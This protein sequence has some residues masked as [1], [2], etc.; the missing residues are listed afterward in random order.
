MKSKFKLFTSLAIA[1][2]AIFSVLL[3]FKGFQNS[4]HTTKAE[5]SYSITLNN[6]NRWTSG[7][8]KKIDTDSKKYQVAFA[9]SGCSSY[10]AGHVTI[11]NEGTLKN[12][13][14]I[15]SITSFYPNFSC[16]DNVDLK[17]RA[18]YDGSH[19]GDYAVVTSEKLFDLSYSKP[20]YLEFKAY[21]G[22]VNLNSLTINYACVINEDAESGAE[23]WE[24][25]AKTSDLEV[26]KQYIITDLESEYG[27]S[28]TQNANN[29]GAVPLANK[30]L[31]INTSVQVVTLLKGNYGENYSLYTGDGYLSA[32]SGNNNY[33]WTVE[34]L[35]NDASW[36][37]SIDSTDSHAFIQ[38]QTSGSRDIL[39][40]NPNTAGDYR[41]FSCYS[42]S[43]ANMEAVLLYKKTNSGGTSVPV[44]PT[45]ID[46]TDS[47]AT[48]YKTNY[49]FAGMIGTE[50]GMNVKLHYSNGS[51]QTLTSQDFT[52]K[53][54]NSSGVEID[55]TKPFPA[56][57]TYQVSITD[58]TFGFKYSYSILVG[59]N[60][61]TSI[62]LNISSISLATDETLQLSVTEILP[63]DA[64]D[65]SITW[66]SS[67]STKAT[68]DQNGFVRAI[69][70][71]NVSITAT[72]NGGNGVVAT[73]NI[74][75]KTEGAAETVQNTYNFAAM[76]LSNLT[77]EYNEVHYD[78]YESRV[79][80]DSACLDSTLPGI[81]VTDGGD[82]Q[83]VADDGY[84]IQSVTINCQKYGSK[85]QTI[86]LYYW[87]EDSGDEGEFVET[88]YSSSNFTLSVGSDFFENKWTDA[89]LFY[90]SSYNEVGIQSISATFYKPGTV[91][92]PV[93][94]MSLSPSTA[95]VLV[96][97]ETYVTPTIVP[98]DATN[99]AINWSTSD[100]S[101]ATVSNGL[102]SGVS[103]GKAT[104]TATTVDGGFVDT[105]EVTVNNRPVTSLTLNKYQ[106]TIYLEGKDLQ[107]TATI[108]ND[109]TI[110][111]LVWESSDTDVATVDNSGKVHAVAEGVSTITVTADGGLTA[112]C[113]VTVEPKQ[114][115]GEGETVT[116]MAT[117]LTSKNDMPFTKDGITISYSKAAGQSDPTWYYDSNNLY[118][119]FR[120]YA[121]NTFTVTGENITFISFIGGN[122]CSSIDSH[123]KA[124]DQFVACSTGSL[125][126]WNWSCTGNGVDEVMF[127]AASTGQ[128]HFTGLEITI[129]DGGG[130]TPTPKPTLSSISVSGPRT[131]FT[132]GDNFIFGG[133]CTAIYSDSSE[134]VV[135]PTSISG[136]NMN[137][138]GQQT[139]TV[140]YKEGDVTETA[141]YTINVEAKVLTLSDITVT[142]GATT[143]TLGDPFS[144]P[145]VIAKFSDGSQVNVTSEATITGYNSS[146]AGKQTI[147]VSYTYNGTTKTKTYTIEVIDPEEATTGKATIVPT[148]LLTSYP[149][150]EATFTKSNMTFGYKSV[151]N[152]SSAGYIQFKKLVGYIRNT[153]AINGL[154]SIEVVLTSGKNFEGTLSSGTSENELTHTQTVN[155]SGT[156]YIESG[157][158]YFKLEDSSGY[159]GYLDSIT[160]NFSTKKVNPTSVYFD[161][162]SLDLTLGETAKLVAK[163]TPEDCNENMGLTWTSSN[164]SVA[165][166]TNGTINALAKGTTTI[167]ATST[168]N[169]SFKATCLITVKDIAVQ[170]I[171][172]DTTSASLNIGSTKQLYATINPS[173]ATN[174]NVTWTST[175]SNV[176][177]VSSTGLVTAKAVGTTTIKVSTQDG[178]KTASCSVEVTEQQ[179]DKWTIM[180]YICGADLES[181][182]GY[183]TSDIKEILGTKTAKPNDVNIIIQTGGTTSWSLGNTYI[184]GT[185]KIDPQKTQ[186]WHVEGSKL[187]LDSSLSKAN[188]GDYKTL[189][190]FYKWGTTSYPAQKTGVILWNHGGGIDGVCWDE[191]FGD[192]CLSMS[193][194]KT[195]LSNAFGSNPSSKLEWIGY[196]ACLMQC[197]EIADYNSK[198]FNYM[199]ASEESESGYGWDYD[200]WLPYVYSGDTT[201]NILKQICYTFI[202]EQGTSSDQTLSY[203]N[204]AYMSEYKTA[205]ENFVSALKTK[206]SNG[207]VTKKTF[208]SFVKSNVKYYS[209]TGYCGWGNIDAK[210][211]INKVAANSS[212]NPGSTYVNAV[213]SAFSNLVEYS[214]CGSGAGNS[215]GLC[216]VY[217]IDKNVSITESNCGFTNWISFNSSYGG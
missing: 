149:T 117:D 99:K 87:D 54:T 151:A 98:T 138:T 39:R 116:I 160:V 92:V 208:Q 191:N 200:K 12:A 48:S 78:Q 110:Q 25:V 17:F 35:S 185:T 81:P 1:G 55:P 10:G 163:F 171:S 85:N 95:T 77:S 51:S 111:T 83:I 148:D 147:T 23:A 203:L 213:L 6:K 166:V 42:S 103:A 183:A 118:T 120:I 74:K 8:T 30:A 152:M 167:T 82:I 144:N 216:C 135:E 65:K 187:V 80:L 96:G 177:S 196:D 91:D 197:Q 140:S 195:A 73:C 115:G 101:V 114:Q 189:E 24:L 72:A 178:N 67:D 69:S 102:V 46:A 206:L 119:E 192:D 155:A 131:S 215:Y 173:N 156:Y 136:Y 97:D 207:G 57:G 170:S 32:Q 145:T 7:S 127:T 176:A 86:T 33:L 106:A 133:V 68:V 164:T 146:V 76:D 217:K 90:F 139:V 20:Y 50:N 194:C 5:I 27:L 134:K 84:Y 130:V 210:D 132:V 75:V 18:S 184:S 28:T 4:F 60:A 94:G 198:Y 22:Q 62:S 105:C 52:Y 9:Y 175:N 201:A 93:T 193:E 137:Q 142:P 47:S 41:L 79:W 100:D 66:S 37:I 153:V 214:R 45:H 43:S 154:R 159:A 190:D 70:S 199:V 36:Y 172:L 63:A 161:Q 181:G 205:F 141:S 13:D 157:D 38:S 16:A 88:N 212:Y 162:T 29:R 126:H 180:L 122:E 11:N 107:L 113:T 61:V 44:Y 34:D 121:N 40:F 64:D 14:H 108:N 165:T 123:K 209:E 112:T 56:S 109:A 182:G 129:G 150:S 174:K 211:F 186:R 128:I 15:L 3:A 59:T 31:N 125:D 2:A 49:S 143:F 26:N 188:F 58:G 202:A 204:L 71:G 158:K 124:T 21:G 53:L 89:V 169:S 179:I 104:I 19:W 168:Y